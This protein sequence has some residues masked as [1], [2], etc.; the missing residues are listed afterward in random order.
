[1]TNRLRNARQLRDDVLGDAVAEVLLFRIA[2]H[3]GEGQDRDRGL[4]RQIA[5]ARLA[6][7]SASRQTGY[8][9][10]PHRLG[11][12]LQ[13]PLTEVLEVEVWSCPSHG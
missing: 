6:V 3:V 5:S 10:D 9:V 11:H 1:M 13:A 4:R 8:P 2:A 12:V 7:P